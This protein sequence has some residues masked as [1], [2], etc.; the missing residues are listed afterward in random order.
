MPDGLEG[1]LFNIYDSGDALVAS[2]VAK[3][4]GSGNMWSAELKLAPG[5]YTVS[6]AAADAYGYALSGVQFANNGGG[7]NRIALSRDARASTPPQA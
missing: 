6:E 1:V 7:R 5:T 3:P 2:A 4:T